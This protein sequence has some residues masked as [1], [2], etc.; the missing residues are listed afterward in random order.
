ME[1]SSCMRRI[2]PRW[3]CKVLVSFLIFLFVRL[4][5][6]QFFVCAFTAGGGNK[7]TMD[8]NTA[9]ASILTIFIVINMMSTNL[10]FRFFAS[11]S[12]LLASIWNR[13]LNACRPWLHPFAHPDLLPLWHQGVSHPVMCPATVFCAFFHFPFIRKSDFSHLHLHLTTLSFAILH[14]FFDSW[15]VNPLIPFLS[16]STILS[17]LRLFQTLQLLTHRRISVLWYEN[18]AT[19]QAVST[20]ESF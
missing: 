3:Q 19:N 2:C 14:L 7:G 1:R 17:S 13:V 9:A 15:T 11:L 12:P 6:K 18:R 5:D 8:G 16:L 10:F 4:V 20:L